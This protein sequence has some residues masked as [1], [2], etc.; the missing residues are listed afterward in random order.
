VNVAEVFHSVQGEGALVGVPSVFVR[1]SGCNLRCRWCD[2]PYTSW[3]PSGTAMTVEQVL[4][5]V[6]RFPSARHV[7]VTGG[8]PMIA[9][10]VD[11]LTRAL[12]ERGLHITIETAGTVFTPVTVDLASIS[13]KLSRSGPDDG[14]W[15][16]RHAA[17]RWA[18]DAIRSLIAAAADHQL[19]FVVETP[20]DV[21]EVKAL[22][23]EL[24]G[25]APPK[26]LLMP[27]ART[28]AELD[29]HQGWIAD[30][31]KAEGFRFCDRLHLRLYGN[32]RG[33]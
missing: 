1:T 22:L 18:P 6:A 3:E 13:P 9:P 24:G 10:G 16:E 11:E 32:K 17:R 5:E 31:C 26:V 4:A 15:R 28:V 7:V 23:A 25:I 12:R 27:Q 30:A 20:A 19:K 8:E 14:P 29:Q 2:T 21:V 33:T